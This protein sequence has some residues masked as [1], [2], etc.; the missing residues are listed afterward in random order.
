[1]ILVDLGRITSHG[2]S[3]HPIINRFVSESSKVSLIFVAAYI[4]I[5]RLLTGILVSV[6]DRKDKHLLLLA[7]S[8]KELHKP[9][10][11]ARGDDGAAISRD[12]DKEMKR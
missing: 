5:S 11:R 7:D 8:L 12:D 2:G 4:C 9:H 6:G 10:C 1:M 3:L